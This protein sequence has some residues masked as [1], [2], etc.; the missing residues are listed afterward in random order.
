[1]KNIFGKI[2]CERMQEKKKSNKCSYFVKGF[3]YLLKDMLEY[4]WNGDQNEG[5]AWVNKEGNWCINSS[6]SW[7]EL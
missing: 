6:S 5:I 1:M 2:K 7:E 3:V 4:G